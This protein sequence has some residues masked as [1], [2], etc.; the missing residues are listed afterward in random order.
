MQAA[1]KPTIYIKPSFL[2]KDSDTLSR[3]VSFGVFAIVVLL[4]IAFVWNKAKSTP[5][6][7]SFNGVINQENKYCESVPSNAD[8]YLEPNA[9]SPSTS[10]P[11][12]LVKNSSANSAYRTT[13]LNAIL[14][15]DNTMWRYTSDGWRDISMM[16][17][18]PRANKIFLERVHP[19]I[20]TAMLLLASLLL[21]IMASSDEEI[22]KLLGRSSQQKKL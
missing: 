9:S 6:S 20:W 19:A 22:K 17:D 3:L 14:L 21:L 16:A 12:R 1:S 5:P 2:D 8:E 11:F 18:P 15:P 4:S 7:Q 13:H 10:T